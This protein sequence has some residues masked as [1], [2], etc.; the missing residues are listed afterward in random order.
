VAW[1]GGAA[2]GGVAVAVAAA[3]LRRAA[4]SAILLAK[5]G[6]SPHRNIT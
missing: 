2:A 6:P 1:R 3:G 4:I 5:R